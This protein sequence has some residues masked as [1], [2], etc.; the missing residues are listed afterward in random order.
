MPD[1]SI[2][3]AALLLTLLPVLT[4]AQGHRQLKPAQPVNSALLKNCQCDGVAAA[5]RSCQ[6]VPPYKGRF[7]NDLLKDCICNAEEAYWTMC[8][9]CL[10]QAISSQPD[11]E[12]TSFYNAFRLAS[13][14]IGRGCIQFTSSRFD[15]DGGRVCGVDPLGRACVTMGESLEEATASIDDLDNMGVATVGTFKLS[16]DKVEKQTWKVDV[17]DPMGEYEGVQKD[18]GAQVDTITVD[19]KKTTTWVESK[20]KESKTVTMGSTSTLTESVT[21][22]ASETGEETGEEKAKVTGV[23][24]EGLGDVWGDSD[25]DGERRTLFGDAEKAEKNGE[26][27]EDKVDKSEAEFVRR[28]STVRTLVG[29]MMVVALFL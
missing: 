18:E 16:F 8:Y 6:V 10:G 2:R 4:T 27:V 26:K 17:R 22:T 14:R 24:G 23:E 7:A 28:R 29:V 11:S 19:G 13:R 12:Q 25:E 3:T 9:E 21:A 15:S 1:F 5:I 20:T